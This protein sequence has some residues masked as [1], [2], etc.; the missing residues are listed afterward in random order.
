MHKRTVLRQTVLIRKIYEISKGIS[1]RSSCARTLWKLTLPSLFV[2]S[3]FLTG[4][5]ASLKKSSSDTPIKISRESGNKIT[6]NITGSQLATKTSDWEQLKAE[7]RDAMK[8]AAAAA[9]IKF[10][11]QEGKP[12]PTGETGTLVVVTVDDY[13][14]ISAGARYGLGVMTGNAFVNSSV[15]FRDLKTGDLLGQR[16]YNTTSSAWEGIFSAMTAKQIQTISADIVNEIQGSQATPRSPN[17]SSDVQ[18]SATDE[19]DNSEK[20]IGLMSC[21][22]RPDN[23]ARGAYQAKFAM[24]VNGSSVHVHRQLPRVAETLSGQIAD[25]MLVL[26]GEGYLTDTPD[27]KWQFRISGDFQPGTPIYSG[28]GDMLANGHAIRACELIM[29]RVTLTQNR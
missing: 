9:G 14:Y 20:W 6:M 12:K 7:W 10:S 3:F 4:C 27:R 18:P 2:A 23:N 29:T 15:Q 22:A 16:S 8:S 25:N 1:M 28:K 26:L 11:S 13:R 17:Q 19:P 21:G 5:A 24:E